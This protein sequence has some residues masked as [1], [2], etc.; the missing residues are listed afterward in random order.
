MSVGKAARHCRSTP[1]SG[2]GPSG[3][4]PMAD[5]SL[6]PAGEA[7][8]ALS[9]KW[10]VPRSCSRG[11]PHSP[12][13]LALLSATGHEDCCP[14]GGPRLPPGSEEE[15][16]GPLSC[17]QRDREYSGSLP[18]RRLSYGGVGCSH[19][20][21]W[22]HTGD[23]LGPSFPPLHLLVNYRAAQ[24]HPSLCQETQDPARRKNKRALS[25]GGRRP[26]QTMELPPS[27]VCGCAGLAWGTQELWWPSPGP[28]FW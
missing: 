24:A 12:L 22:E 21:P 28:C 27:V 3:K 6:G 23:P 17:R 20:C 25:P 18:D 2:P 26:A 1:G 16:A 10:T 15:L 8:L 7:R 11:R 14:L 19:R 13:P 5:S 9:R 4:L